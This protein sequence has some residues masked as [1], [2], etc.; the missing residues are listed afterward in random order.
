MTFGIIALLAAPA[1]GPAPTFAQ[2]DVIEVAPF[3]RAVHPPVQIVAVKGGYQVYLNRRT[4]EW[5]ADALEDVDEKDVAARLRK[6]AKEKKEADSPDE[7]AAR[8]LEMIAFAVSTQLPGFRKALAEKTGPGGAV[9]TLT[10]FQSP[11]V[12]FKKPRPKLQKA[13][14]VVRG[15]MPLLPGEA[16]EVVEALR[17]VARTKPLFWKVEPRE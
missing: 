13:A 14:E 16:R 7:D 8:T 1:A 10:G 3:P 2:P 9:V 17:A 5:L 15:V 11:A 12:K 4:A 6:R